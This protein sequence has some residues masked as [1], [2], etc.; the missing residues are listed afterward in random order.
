M[1]TG[2]DARGGQ[3]SVASTGRPTTLRRSGAAASA[4]GTWR[5]CSRRNAGESGEAGGNRP[6]GRQRRAAAAAGER[7]SQDGGDSEEGRALGGRELGLGHR[8]GEKALRRLGG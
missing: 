6:D 2:P 3:R 5:R 7:E 8:A 1:V 4:M